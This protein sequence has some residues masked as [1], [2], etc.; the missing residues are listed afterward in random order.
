MRFF[1]FKKNVKLLVAIYYKFSTSWS[2]DDS[3]NI[4]NN[5][6]TKN[7][8]Q[9]LPPSKLYRTKYILCMPKHQIKILNTYNNLN[10]KISSSKIVYLNSIRYHHSFSHDFMRLR[11]HETPYHAAAE[12]EVGIENYWSPIK[13]RWCVNIGIYYNIFQAIKTEHFK[14]LLLIK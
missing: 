14:N 4:F 11:S 9:Q 6:A 10:N 12:M 5:E 2:S 3:N 7:I 8:L 1:F 13:D